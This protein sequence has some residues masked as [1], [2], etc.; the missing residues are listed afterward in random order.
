MKRFLKISSFA[1]ATLTA[2]FFL[3]VWLLNHHPDEIENSPITCPANAPILSKDQ[4]VKVMSWNVQYMASKNYVFFYDQPGESG[5]DDRPSSKDIAFTIEEVGRVIQAINPDIILL[6]EL[7]DNSKRTDYTDQLEA[8][9]TKI[10]PKYNCFSQAY[11]HKSYFVPH[12]HIMGSVGMKLATLSRYRI[13][14]A[15]RHQLAKIP[16]DFVTEQFNFKRAI[17]EIR[18][19]VQ[20]AKDFVVFNTHLDAFAQG[21]NTMEL[22]VAE[23]IQLLNNAKKQGNKFVIGGDFNLLP[24]GGHE[25]LVNSEKIYFKKDTEIA[26]LYKLFPGLPTVDDTNGEEREKFFTHYP[27]GRATGPDRTIDYFFYHPDMKLESF[28]VRQED[29]LKISDHLPMIAEFMLE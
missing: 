27:N 8:L 24:P 2:L 28:L 14:K 17:L 11:Y 5:P 4:K 13:G 29:T 12:P 1:L 23:V 18:L 7:D 10:S 16:N 22:Q 9:K 6:Q 19:P 3:L 25:K 20:D 26:K 15:V 21:S